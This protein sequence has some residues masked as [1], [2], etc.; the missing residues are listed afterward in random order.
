MSGP[1]DRIGHAHPLPMGAPCAPAPVDMTDPLAVSH[2]A[3]RTA[4]ALDRMLVELGAQ[5][6]QA[7]AANDAEHEAVECRLDL[8]DPRLDRI[9]AALARKDENGRPDV[10]GW[11]TQL[12]V[13][14]GA[15]ILTMLGVIGYLLDRGHFIDPT[16][17][18]AASSAPAASAPA[19]PPGR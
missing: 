5:V 3:L 11:R 19:R 8:I 12:L 15:V 9:E 14:A 18:P 6:E 17:P 16:P 7:R 10:N 13:I 4:S 2:E 1:V